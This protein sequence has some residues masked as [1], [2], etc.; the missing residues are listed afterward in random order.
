M[1]SVVFLLNMDTDD[2]SNNMTV[3][4]TNELILDLTQFNRNIVYQVLEDNTVAVIRSEAG[5]DYINGY[6]PKDSYIGIVDI[7]API[8]YKSTVDNLQL[9]SYTRLPSPS[10]ASS[11]GGGLSIEIRHSDIQCAMVQMIPGF[12]HSS[13]TPSQIKAS[14]EAFDIQNFESGEKLIEFGSSDFN[15]YYLMS[16]LAHVK[17]NNNVVRVLTPCTSVFG[18]APFLTDFSSTKPMPSTRS[19]DVI[20]SEKSHVMVIDVQKLYNKFKDF[21]TNPYKAVKDYMLERFNAL[22]F[23]R[24]SRGGRMKLSV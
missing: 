11:G 12:S 10:P 18:E 14:L 2:D 8:R 1:T 4:G 13:I 21:D 6:L 3:F 23:L 9:K 20:A 16:G 24:I 7:F 15:L 17:S 19:A 22:E 5:I